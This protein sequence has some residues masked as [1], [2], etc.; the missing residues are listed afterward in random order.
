MSQ[1]DP[2]DIHLFVLARIS[3]RASDDGSAGTAR[4]G[5]RVP[6]AINGGY[7]SKIIMKYKTETFKNAVENKT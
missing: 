6:E 5:V 3:K 1:V 4:C 2:F 7:S